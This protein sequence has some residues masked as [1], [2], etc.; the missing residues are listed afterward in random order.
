MELLVTYDIESVSPE[1]A[2]RLRR[3]AKI[4]EGHGYR[5][6]KS[7]F[8]ITCTTPDRLRLEAAL[9]QAIKPGTDSVRIYPLDGGTLRAARHLGRAVDPPHDAPLIL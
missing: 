9:A 1:G 5:V 6:Q 7:V 3:V 8:E 2:A 4:C